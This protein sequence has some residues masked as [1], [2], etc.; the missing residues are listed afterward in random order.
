[1]P[2]R[3]I[4]RTFVRIKAQPAHAVENGLDGFRSGTLQIGIF[5]A[6]DELPFVTACIRPAEQRGAR[7]ANVQKTGRAGG[8][9]GTDGGHLAKL[10]VTATGR[11]GGK[12]TQTP[13]HAQRGFLKLVGGTGIEPVTPAV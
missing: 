4:E 8:E 11:T 12:K 5:N 7:T 2:L 13:E 6:Q 3:L 9:T 1:H 10:R